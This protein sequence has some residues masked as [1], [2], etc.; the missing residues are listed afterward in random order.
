MSSRP[1]VMFHGRASVL[2][3][4]AAYVR[5]LILRDGMRP[6]DP[7]PSYREISAQLGVAYLTVKRAMDMLANEGLVVR[8]RGRGCVLAHDPSTVPRTLKKL[9]L[10]FSLSRDSTHPFAVDYT[11]AVVLGIMTE[12]H[13][14]GFD[15]QMFSLTPAERISPAVLA[16]NAID[17]IIFVGVENEDYLCQ[18]ASWRIPVV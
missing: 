18:A 17:G 11:G 2:E 4:V 7:L 14:L 8:H 13:R 5:A 12:C 16:D 9:G 3:Q 1:Q 6:G 10:I 15:A